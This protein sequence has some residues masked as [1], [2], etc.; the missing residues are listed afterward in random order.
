MIFGG[1]TGFIASTLFLFGGGDSSIVS[2]LLSFPAP[3]DAWFAID[4]L[5]AF[6]L[7]F[8]YAG[9][10]LTSLYSLGYLPK[11]RG[12]YSLPALNAALA[13]FVFGMGAT[14]MSASIFS[15][16][17]F[18]KV[19]SVSAYFLVI[20][21][22]SAE[23]LSAGFSYFL[24]THIGFV[25]LLAGFLLLSGGNVFASFL[26][27]AA[28]AAGLSSFVRATAFFLLFIGF[29]SKAGLVPLHQWLPY[30]HPQ[31]P[32]NASALMSGVMLKVA[33][34][35]F[36]QSLFLFS[37]IP[38]WWSC[39]VM[40][41]GLVSAF[42]GVLHA[43][44]ESDVKRLLAWS[45][46]EN[47]GLLFSALGGIGIIGSLPLGLGAQPLIGALA[48]FV[49]LHAVNH[50]L[51][52]SGLFM[53]AGAVV[54]ETHTRDLDQLG[55]LAQ[56]WPLFSAAFL[57]LSLAASALP[58]FGAF[59]GEWAYLQ[60]LVAAIGS[61]ITALA[62]PAGVALSLISLISGLAI[63]TFAKAFSSIFLGRARTNHAEN[64][65][66]LH[67]ALVT[68]VVLTAV[69]SLATGLVAVPLGSL[70][71]GATSTGDW[72]A[73][74][75]PLPRASINPL[76]VL[77]I[78]MLTLTLAFVASRIFGAPRIRRT[79]TWD[80][81]QPLTR[82]MEYT[83]T[84]FA[85]PIRFFFKSIVLAEKRM[86]AT[87]IIAS[88]PWIAS[89]SLEWKV[90]SFWERALYEPLGKLMLR[91]ADVIKHLQSGV[92]QFYL[93]LVFATLVVVMSTAL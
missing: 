22:R 84:G 33:L 32:S 46:I 12:V 21:D 40:A 37:E 29:G 19:M 28:S 34:F 69:A 75:A 70:I 9:M 61:G 20:A 18:W 27:I 71:A 83:A 86:T 23:S 42:F 30:A 90:S 54:S 49:A 47:M 63:F 5:R 11:Y 88:N 68:P 38:L 7:L 3:L 15:F 43:A 55:G 64:V 26:S 48:F 81:G 4:T 62:V 85:A 31:A 79:D 52:K 17:L 14:I 87:P 82:R 24:M 76:V 89:R 60:T 10:M 93:L 45:S 8:V 58:P 16:L 77:L 50:F 13:L 51:F 78:V 57:A 65:G 35:G 56:K 6:F 73:S 1:V 2:G 39:V 36:I 74:L 44:V 66:H 72:S 80:C 25:S 91:V 59:Y 53:A 92:V 41:V 67:W